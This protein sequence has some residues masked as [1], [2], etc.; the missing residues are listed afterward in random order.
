LTELM[1]LAIGGERVDGLPFGQEPGPHQ[2][3][4]D[5]VEERVTVG[6]RV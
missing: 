6:R 1:T 4:A 5:T 2:I 3:A